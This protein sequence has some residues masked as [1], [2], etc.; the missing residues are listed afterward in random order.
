MR[1][2]EFGP[3]DDFVLFDTDRAAQG[4]RALGHECRDAT[5]QDAVGLMDLG[6][7]FDSHDDF[8]GGEQHD[9][10]AQH[11]VDVV[12]LVDSPHP[13]FVHFDSVEVG[14]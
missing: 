1:A 14:R 9:F 3:D 4:R 2:V 13:V 5:V 7:D 11:L 6:S 8:L 12:V 10:D